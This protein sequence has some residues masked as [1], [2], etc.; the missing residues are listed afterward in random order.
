MSGSTA[1]TS[2]T[3]RS[4]RG[5]TYGLRRHRRRWRFVI[6]SASPRTLRQSSWASYRAVNFARPLAP[7]LRPIQA[8]YLPEVHVGDLISDGERNS[9]LPQ[10]AQSLKLTDRSSISDTL[11]ADSLPPPAEWSQRRYR[12]MNDFEFRIRDI[13]EKG[14]SQLPRHRWR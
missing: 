7:T 1:C 11:I 13:P 2:A 6:S 8:A 12:V 3:T 10:A 4:R 9:C 5:W 14:C